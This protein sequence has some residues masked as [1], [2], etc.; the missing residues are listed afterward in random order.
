MNKL[1]LIVMGVMLIGVFLLA[2]CA[3]TEVAEEVSETL[4]VEAPEVLVIEAPV[5]AEEAYP[6]EE[7]VLMPLVAYP[8]DEEQVPDEEAALDDED[9]R[10][11]ALISEKIG[12]C[13]VLNFILGQNKTREE[14]SATIDRMIGKGAQVNAEE[15]DLIIDWLVSREQ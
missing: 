10:M 11:Q 15:K 14:W 2:G 1:R 13:H 6:V 3:Q 5:E 7:I 9:A 4:T 12:G 8:V